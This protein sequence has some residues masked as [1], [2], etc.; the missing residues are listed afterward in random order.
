MSVP[1]LVNGIDPP[2][3]SVAFESYRDRQR[4]ATLATE[5]MLAGYSVWQSVRNCDTIA[6]GF[7]G[8]YDGFMSLKSYFDVKYRY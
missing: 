5:H 4:R 7:G 2:S 6:T 8:L 3:T 1:E